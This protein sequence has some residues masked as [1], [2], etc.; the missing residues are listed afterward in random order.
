MLARLLAR[1]GDAECA[2]VL[3]DALRE[4]T[5]SDDSYVAGPLAVAQLEVG[6]LTGSGIPAAAETAME[7]AA[8]TGHTA[9]LGELCV[10]LRRAGRSVKAPFG[11]PEPWA[12]GLA[13]R[14]RDA[15]AGWQAL[16]ERYEHAVELASAKGDEIERSA[17]LAMLKDL[18]ASAT[19]GA[20]SRRAE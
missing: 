10:Y 14:W 5:G 19:V 8:A 3:N 15:A 18:G 13:G 17:G 11:V 6:W 2:Q 7:L 12:A 1:R 9:M 4:A 20:L 16:G